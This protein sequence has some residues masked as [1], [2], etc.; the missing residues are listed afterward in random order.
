LFV[1]SFIH[2]FIHPFIHPFIHSSIL[3]VASDAVHKK[4][5]AS[6]YAEDEEILRVP[7]ALAMVKLL[8]H[9]PR[10][11]LNRTLPK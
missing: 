9:L 2:S 11:T 1:C 7:L 5:S 6:K 8:Q 10:G 4:A 3:Q